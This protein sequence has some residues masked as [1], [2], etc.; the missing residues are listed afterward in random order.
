MEIKIHAASQGESGLGLGF[1]KQNR[2]SFLFISPTAWIWT[3]VNFVFT[4][5]KKKFLFKME[6]KFFQI[7]IQ[8]LNEFL[9]W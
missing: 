3:A 7:L 4:A 6:N 9:I 8:W 5:K 2:K 1:K